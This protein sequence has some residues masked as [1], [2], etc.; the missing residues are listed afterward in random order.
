MSAAS[1]SIVSR[2]L[3]AVA[4]ETSSTPPSFTWSI[5]LVSTPV[6]D[7]R[8]AIS[9]TVSSGRSMCSRSMSAAYLGDVHL[10]L[11]HPDVAV[12]ADR[13]EDVAVVLVLGGQ[14]LGLA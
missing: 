5:T 2:P 14:R 10:A 6:S 7:S 12:R 4:M 3:G 13:D 11:V 8:S 9:T 1:A